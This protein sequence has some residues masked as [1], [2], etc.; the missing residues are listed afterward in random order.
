MIV[1]RVAGVDIARVHQHHRAALDLEARLFVQI[2]TASA[3]DRANGKM[4]VGVARITDLAAI[5]DGSGLDKGQRRVAPEAWGGV[6][7]GG[8]H[9]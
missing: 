6:V 2:G 4:V 1:D 8:L 5:G 9:R 3:R 7:V